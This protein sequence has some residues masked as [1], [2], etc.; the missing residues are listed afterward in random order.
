MHKPQSP[1]WKLYCPDWSIETSICGAAGA[2]EN[3]RID[4]MNRLACVLHVQ[5]LRF[6]RDEFGQ[7][8]FHFDW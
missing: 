8:T 4:K 7:V 5:P 1:H 3:S 2:G 6:L